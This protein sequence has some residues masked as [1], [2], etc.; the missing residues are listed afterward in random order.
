MARRSI[1]Q[2]EQIKKDLKRKIVILTG[3]RQV[4][5]T[6]LSQNLLKD[7]EYLNYDSYEHRTRIIKS[8]WDRNK[9][10]II[11]DEIHKRKNWKSWLKGIYDTQ[12]RPPYFLVT[13]SAKLDVVKKMGDSLAGR[14]FQHRLHP[15][16]LKE[17][18]GQYKSD[19][20]FQRLLKLGGFPEPFQSDSEEEA[21]RWRKTHL[22]II[23]RQDLTDLESVRNIH[24]IETLI[25]LLRER[26]GSGIS[27][28]SL[29][30]DLEV[31][32]KT[33]KNW[34]R[35]LEE[36]YI[37][38]SITPYSSKLT[39]SILKEPKI[40]FYDNG[41]VVGDNGAKFENLVAAALLKELHSLEDLKG[42]S[43]ALHYLKTKEGKE[44]NFLVTIER[45][46]VLMLEAKWSDG[47]I[48]SHLSHFKDF[49]RD[50]KLNS[51]IQA[52]QLVAQR[53]EERKNAMGIDLKN[54][55]PWL[56]DMPILKSL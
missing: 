27:Y 8:D 1:P 13:G 9:E 21:S 10:L 3:P 11:L 52:I 40:Y 47:N 4:G 50:K 43:T 35:I 34:I 20:I 18:K 55:I 16:D 15:F 31:D 45:K 51:D 32:P 25:L 36:L 14:Y 54:A 41:Q 2:I 19:V 12:K 48:S 56:E 29:A 26:V 22:D 46:P 30:R 28:A 17:L 42:K 23:L 49:F 53:I 5:K 37:I 39:R 33:V 6:T 44:I 24:G 7:Y 38:F